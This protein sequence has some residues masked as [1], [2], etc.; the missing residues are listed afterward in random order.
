MFKFEW[1][2]NVLA[3][4]RTASGIGTSVGLLHVSICTAL[5]L[6]MQVWHMFVVCCILLS[7]GLQCNCIIV[8]MK[9]Y[10]IILFLRLHSVFQR[11]ALYALSYCISGIVMLLF[12]VFY[13]NSLNSV[14]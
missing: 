5:I 3:T 13:V 2:R 4:Y 9:A 1:L 7:S 14:V 6:S 12:L 10:E 8:G 11:T